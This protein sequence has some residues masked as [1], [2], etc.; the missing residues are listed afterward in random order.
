VGRW[1]EGEE[2]VLISVVG[3][4]TPYFFFSR[5]PIK[6][7]SRALSAAADSAKRQLMGMLGRSVPVNWTLRAVSFTSLGKS[8]VIKSLLKM[9]S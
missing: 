1:K 4:S 8:C 5:A 7:A 2:Y 3:A 9:P 6:L